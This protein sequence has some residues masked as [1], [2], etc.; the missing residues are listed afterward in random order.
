MKNE[1]LEAKIVRDGKEV[2]R[3]ELIARDGYIDLARVR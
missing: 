2:R 3:I 1:P